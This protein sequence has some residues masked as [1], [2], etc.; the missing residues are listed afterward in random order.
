MIDGSPAGDSYKPCDPTAKVSACCAT[1][2]ARP[3]ICLSSGLCYAQDEGYKG[4]IYS[5]GCTDKSGDA[6]ACP[7]FCPDRTNDWNGGSPIAS[8]NILQCNPGGVYCCRAYNDSNNC[9]GDTAA[10]A[11][12]DI[13]TLLLSAQ[14]TSV[15]A[16][17]TATI[18]TTVSVTPSSAQSSSAQQL[19][20]CPKDKTAVV[21][22]AV[23]GVLGAAL[24][25]SLGVIAALFKRRPKEQHEP[26]FTPE[27]PKYMGIPVA[28][29]PPQELNAARE[30]HEIQGNQL[31]EYRN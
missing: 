17:S 27:S 31:Y 11:T 24:L 25:A 4:L 9:C 5:N 12:F 29:D 14:T 21:G 3:D 19:S 7:H 28:S 2:K 18:T 20:D 26:Q 10:V 8:Y 30:V 15:A 22:G 13:G 6:T 16:G 23:G 1:N